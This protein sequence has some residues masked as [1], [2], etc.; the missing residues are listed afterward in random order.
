MRQQKQ[1]RLSSDKF[2]ISVYLHNP[3]NTTTENTLSCLRLHVS[4]SGSHQAF[5]RAQKLKITVA[6]CT[7]DPCVTSVKTTD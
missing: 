4:T 7:W 3:S 2:N 6:E 5:L 1:G